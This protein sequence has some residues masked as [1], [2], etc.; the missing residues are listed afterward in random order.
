M[1]FLLRYHRMGRYSKSLAEYQSLFDASQLKVLLYE[2]LR[3]NP[4]V[5]EFY[6][7]V[8]QGGSRKSFKDVKSYKRRKRWM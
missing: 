8:T 7:G 1:E 5:K 2:D 6:M 4:D 3:N